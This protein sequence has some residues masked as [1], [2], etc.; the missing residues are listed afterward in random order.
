MA[1]LETFLLS[2][3]SRTEKES[4]LKRFMHRIWSEDCGVLSF[5]WVLLISL[6]TLGIVSGV[7]G[8]RD[9][10]IDELGDSAQAMMA[11]DQSFTIDFPL[12]VT[13]DGVGG[14]GNDSAYTDSAAFTDC[15]RV[16][17]PLGQGHS[18]DI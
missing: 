15:D 17:G 16:F 3:V 5:E 8:A 1:S 13:I 4:I 9:A 2:L 11:L 14:R 18:V 6:L 10:I 7:V 12:M